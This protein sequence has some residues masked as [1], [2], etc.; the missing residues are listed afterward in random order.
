MKTPYGWIYT[1]K[2]ETADGCWAT[3][4]GNA[5]ADLPLTETGV[6]FGILRDLNRELPGFPVFRSEFT[7]FDYTVIE[8]VPLD[9]TDT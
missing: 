9:G 1:A 6:K 4:E 8:P 5:Y 7:R 2:V 3:V